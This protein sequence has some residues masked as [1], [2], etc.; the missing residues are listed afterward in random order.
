MTQE[1]K[2]HLVHLSSP[3]KRPSQRTILGGPNLLRSGNK[4]RWKSYWKPY[5]DTL[6]RIVNTVISL[7]D[8]MRLVVYPHRFLEAEDTANNFLFNA[9]R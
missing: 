8:M 9:D 5:E 6:V 3:V 4:R 1:L 7:F 2:I